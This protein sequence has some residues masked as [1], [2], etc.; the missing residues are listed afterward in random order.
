ME[1]LLQTLHAFSISLGV[2]CSTVAIIS[3]LAMAGKQL[4]RDTSAYFMQIV[5]TLLRV[6]MGGILITAALLA[7]GN[8]GD[9]YLTT[10]SI[11]LWLLIGV[12]YSNAVLMT[13]HVMPRTIGPG[14]QAATWYGLGVLTAVSTVI[15]L[16]NPYVLGLG[17]VVWVVVVIVI[18]NRVMQYRKNK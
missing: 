12:L 4:D 1:A 2:G 13:T 15:S 18:V 5:F 10:E 11:A 8:W 14:L 7:V 17:Y 3:F 6:A 16:P 9:G